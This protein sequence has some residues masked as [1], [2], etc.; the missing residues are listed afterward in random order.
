[1]S[2]PRPSPR[3]RNGGVPFLTLSDG[4]VATFDTAQSTGLSFVFVYHVGAG[5]LAASLG[6][7]GFDL[8]GAAIS[9]VSAGDP[10]NLSA[11]FAPLSLNIQIDTA[12]AIGA[13]GVI[14]DGSIIVGTDGQSYLNA[15]GLG[16]DAS[17]TLTG[18]AESGDRW[19]SASTARP[20]R[21][22]RSTP[23]ATGR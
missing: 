9:G 7:S 22:P 23:T 12:T 6:V 10:V 2:A 13:I 18:S 20:P 14:S 5:D 17:T 11:A 1:M 21:R 3:S 8:N 4:G 16:T 19:P 15:A